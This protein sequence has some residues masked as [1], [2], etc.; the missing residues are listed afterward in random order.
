[1]RTLKVWLASDEDGDPVLVLADDDTTVILDYG[2]G[3]HAMTAAIEA[4]SR[5][6][7]AAGQYENVLHE[8]RAN[9]RGRL[10]SIDTIRHRP[11]NP[12]R[13]V[14]RVPPCPWACRYLLSRT[15]LRHRMEAG[16][17]SQHSDPRILRKVAVD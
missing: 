6:A 1:M 17:G 2:L 12:V 9:R 11:V 7:E 16:V 10:S 3:G 13:F 14:I 4:A 15:V 5:L 8:V